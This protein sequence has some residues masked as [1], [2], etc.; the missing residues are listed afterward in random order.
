VKRDVMHSTVPKGIPSEQS[1]AEDLL[2]RYSLSRPWDKRA[3]QI[4]FCVALVVHMLVM[5][6]SF[7]EQK[8]AEA[9]SKPKRVAVIR[10]YIPPPP[11][12][13]RPATSRAKTKSKRKIPIPD[14][15]PDY[16]E[17]IVEPEP[18][19]AAPPLPPGLDYMIGAPEPPPGYEYGTGGGGT[20]DGPLLAGTGGV[21][22]PVRIEESYVK[23]EFPE[24]A[25]VA[26]TSA[27]VIL[28]AIIYH[29]GTVGEC[30][31]LRCTQ[32]GYGFEEKAIAAVEQWR[33]EPA[34]QNGEPVTVYFTI[35]VDFDVL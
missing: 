11:Q 28:Q 12:F 18:E 30:T 15:T 34:T 10:K 14:P 9:P 2:K 13:Q 4:G 25:R 17:P 8:K 22:N 21:T 29:D 19:I 23:P 20:G 1:I 26:R 32:Q 35:I 33:Y 6:V 27:E 31:C 16:P 7:P 5:L 3:M 24:L